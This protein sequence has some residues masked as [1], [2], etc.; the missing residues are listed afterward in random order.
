MVFFE[1]IHLE[2][3]INNKLSIKVTVTSTQR[4]PRLEFSHTGWVQLIRS[5]LLAR[6]SFELSGNLNY[7][8]FFNSK[9]AKSFELENS[10]N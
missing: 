8:L 9:F 6:F 5:H 4:F 1:S 10:L 3:L 7:R 2:I